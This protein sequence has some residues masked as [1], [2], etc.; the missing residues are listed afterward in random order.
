M[1]ALNKVKSDN[2][3]DNRSTIV[4]KSEEAINI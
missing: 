3:F 2:I 1:E 4:H